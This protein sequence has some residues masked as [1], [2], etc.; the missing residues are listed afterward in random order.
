MLELGI[1][2]ENIYIDKQSGKDF[3][4]PDYEKLMQVLRA[5]DL[6]YVPTIKRLG[7]DYEEIPN[8]W[9]II[10][11][12]IG[13]DIVVIDMPLLDTRQYKDLLGTF[14][15]DI[16][17]QVLSFCAHN[18]RDDIRANQADGIRKAKLRGV[19]F[20][21]PEKK[22]PDNFPELVKQWECKQLHLSEV[23]EICGFEKTTFYNALREY[24]IMQGIIKK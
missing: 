9:R 19:K 17:L 6:L 3:N 24:R 5:G 2:R 21:R 16:V 8:Q 1:P 15:A 18:E 14:I 20:G 4:R 13:A 12:E 11:K 23:L 10:T 7:R 22:P